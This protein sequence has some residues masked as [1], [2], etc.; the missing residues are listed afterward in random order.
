M[1]INCPCI[2][3]VRTSFLLSFRRRQRRQRQGLL[4]A[5]THTHTPTCKHNT[6]THTDS[7]LRPLSHSKCF[8]RSLSLSPLLFSFLL[9][10]DAK[11]RSQQRRRQH[12]RQSAG[13]AVP[14]WLISLVCDFNII[15]LCFCSGSLACP[16]WLRA[17]ASASNSIVVFQ[18]LFSACSVHSRRRCCRR[19]RRRR[20]FL[21][22]RVFVFVAARCL[23]AE[24]KS[25]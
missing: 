4:L 21:C 14:A 6:H 25:S 2:S 7:F 5:H 20:H 1:Q 22:F 18:F 8:A 19:Q 24:S 10:F 3:L 9:L 17:S 13:L 23:N 12:W 15:N 16:L 11:A